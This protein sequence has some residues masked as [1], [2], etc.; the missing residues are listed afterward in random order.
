ALAGIQLFILASSTDRYFSWTI[1]IPLTAAF[2]GAGYWASV[3]LEW[4]SGRERV[5]ARCRPAVSGVFVFTVLTLVATVLHIDRFHLGDE[6]PLH[7]QVVTWVWIAVYLIVPVA[8]VLILR[9]QL[10]QPGGEPPRVRPLPTW[11][12]VAVCA[13]A[14]VMLVLGA[15]LFIAPE[16]VSPWWP[17]PLTPLTGRAVA[18]WLVALGVIA[19]QVVW[20]NDFTRTRPVWVSNVVLPILQVIALSRY[21]DSL[22]WSP[23]GQIYLMFLISLL[24]TGIYGVLRGYNGPMGRAA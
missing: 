4:L 15:A 23:E 6:F 18:A 1:G 3:P 17:W 16:R 24:L 20:E 9:D 14:A 19:L 12:R 13:Q 11:M 21:S 7:T 5:W 22:D 2:L 8:F 10:R